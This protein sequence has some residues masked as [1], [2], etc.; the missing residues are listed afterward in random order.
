MADTL[1][2]DPAD[3]LL[4]AP[5]GMH[6]DGSGDQPIPD[7]PT[8]TL[9]EVPEG[10]VPDDAMP[11]DVVPEDVALDTLQLKSGEY[12]GT[13]T[14]APGSHSA[15]RHRHPDRNRFGCP[16]YLHTSGDVWPRNAASAHI[17]QAP[18]N[19]RRSPYYICRLRYLA[20]DTELR[21]S[22]CVELGI[23][24]VLVPCH[25]DS[26]V[27]P[28]LRICRHRGPLAILYH[29]HSTAISI[30]P[31]CLA[32]FPDTIHYTYCHPISLSRPSMSSCSVHQYVLWVSYDASRGVRGV[33]R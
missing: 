29:L 3:L 32:S 9:P 18:S 2:T 23:H 28:K 22:L 8:D 30:L 10:V 14:R 20:P 19:R 26:Y 13:R 12:V 5:G 27:C 31:P 6:Q 21:P 24:M 17:L 11:E 4:P 16:A 33:E 25:L 1:P 7:I 15:A